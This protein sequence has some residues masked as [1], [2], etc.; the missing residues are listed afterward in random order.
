MATRIVDRRVKADGSRSPS[1]VRDVSMA[2]AA[3]AESAARD[4]R[5]ASPG[6]SG[7]GS[8]IETFADSRTLNANTND[9][10]S[11]DEAGGPV[12]F[13]SGVQYVPGKLIVLS[14]ATSVLDTLRC[15]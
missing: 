7:R 15:S 13:G 3:T 4:A 2:L 1:P 11:H 14:L 8:L 10:I 9:D 5:R 6:S 12:Y